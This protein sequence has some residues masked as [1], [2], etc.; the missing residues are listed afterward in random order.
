MSQSQGHML[1]KGL[2]VCSYKNSP[3][4]ES[5]SEL[6]RPS[7]RRVCLYIQIKIVNILS[8]ATKGPKDKPIVGENKYETVL[9]EECAAQL[10]S[11]H[12][13]NLRAAFNWVKRELLNGTWTLQICSAS[14][15]NVLS[16]PRLHNRHLIWN[17]ISLPLLLTSC[18]SDAVSC[19]MSTKLRVSTLQTKELYS[20]A[21]TATVY[22]HFRIKVGTF[23]V[24][25]RHRPAPR[26]VM[27]LFMAE[28]TVWS[29]SL[30]SGV[31]YNK[32]QYPYS[33]D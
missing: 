10:R 32:M 5:A 6:Y 15:G 33:Q 31:W 23:F 26:Y 13:G 30:E 27:I 22:R 4:S 18:M 12:G 19:S 9:W 11:G 3:W 20:Y 8:D 1:L 17:E 21:N 2:I 29:R 14:S 24:S 7:D 28:S 16:I 25:T